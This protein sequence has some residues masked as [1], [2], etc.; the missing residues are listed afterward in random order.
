MRFSKSWIVTMKDLSVLIKK[1]YILYS[2]VA[3]PLMLG[4][5]VPSISLYA[6][7]SQ[8]AQLTAAQFLASAKSLVSVSSAYFV[9]IAAILPTIIASYSFL[10]EKL[11]KSMEPLLATPITDSELLFGKSIGAFI[12]CMGATYVGTAIFAAIVDV[13]S[14]SNFGTYLVP[15]AFW[16]V[17]MGV[18]TPLTCIFSVE[19]NVIISSRVADIRAAQQIG[20]LIVLPLILLVVLLSSSTSIPNTLLALITS[21]AL[22]IADVAL[23]FLSKATFQREEILTKWK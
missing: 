11:E 6:L 18:M 19:A 5:V 13:W 12:P 8:A 15:N 1:K 7:Q 17:I 2:L 14:Y 21:S 23:F 20:G 9:V 3:L 10:G 22:A 16:A 4:L